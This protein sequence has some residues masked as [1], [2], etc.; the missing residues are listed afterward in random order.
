MAPHHSAKRL[1][2]WII[3]SSL[4]LPSNAQIKFSSDFLYVTTIQKDTTFTHYQQVIVGTKGTTDICF[5]FEEDIH[6]FYNMTKI[7]FLPGKEVFYKGLSDEGKK[8]SIRQVR[9]KEGFMF[10]INN[11]EGGY[12]HWYLTTSAK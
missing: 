4:C 9:E 11:I 5:A 10:W 3:A 12:P 7:R 6:C 2:L 1:C 8:Y